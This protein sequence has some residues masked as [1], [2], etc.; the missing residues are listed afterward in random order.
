MEM[1]AEQALQFREDYMHVVGS[2]VDTYH[3]GHYEITSLVIVPKSLALAH[4]WTE[5]NKACV[6]NDCYV[7]QRR[8]APF[9]VMCTERYIDAYSAARMDA[10]R[11]KSNHPSLSVLTNVLGLLGIEWSVDKYR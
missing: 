1:Q 8:M 2:L 6:A 3:Y 7:Y 9:Y 4:V 10:S 5:Q 11:S